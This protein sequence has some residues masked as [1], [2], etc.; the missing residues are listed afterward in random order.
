MARP[1]L[2]TDPK[3]VPQPLPQ[4]FL[5]TPSSDLRWH[6]LPFAQLP[7]PALYRLLA[8]RSQVFVVEQRCFYQDLDG[9]DFGALQVFATAG[10][11]EQVV[12]TARLLP[13][14]V[15]FSEPSIGRVCVDSACRGHGWGR[16]LVEFALR[17][18][19]EHHPGRPIRISAQA[20]LQAFYE[21]LGF[22]AASDRYLEDG[23]AHV[24]MLRDPQ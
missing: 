3:P 9:A 22:V 7:V 18:T 6:C 24:E 21:S 20:H 11:D 17:C 14:G 2:T 5:E 13:P 16:L 23:I 8:L 19:G 10:E 1:D 15:R 4:P 12:A